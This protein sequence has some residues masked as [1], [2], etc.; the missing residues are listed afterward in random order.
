MPA[1]AAMQKLGEREE[2]ETVFGTASAHSP[3]PTRTAKIIVAFTA[4]D[5]SVLLAAFSASSN[6]DS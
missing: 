2:G 1:N 3:Y 6:S 4:G 5:V